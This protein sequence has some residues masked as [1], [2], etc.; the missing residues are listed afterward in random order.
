V[1]EFDS[2][3]CVFRGRERFRPWQMGKI[4]ALI[5]FGGGLPIPNED[6]MMRDH[7][8]RGRKLSCDAQRAPNRRR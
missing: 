5:F 7:M 2:T 8:T 6:E 1:L 4:R 3:F